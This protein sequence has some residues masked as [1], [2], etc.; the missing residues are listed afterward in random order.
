MPITIVPVQA[1]EGLAEFVNL[2]WTVYADDPSW[3]PPLRQQ[4]WHELSDASAFAS[5]GRRQLYLCEVDGRPVGRIGASVN[6]RLV[7]ANGVV[8]GQLGYF[9]CVNDQT[10]AAALVEAGVAWL[11][12]QGAGEIIGPMNGGAH[13]T[14]RFMTRGFDRDPFMFEVR[15]PS[16]Y[17]TLFEGCGFVAT[18][19]W[20]GFELDR[21]RA[22]TLVAQFDRV[23]TRRPPPGR[24]VDMAAEPL[25]AIV[26]RLHRLLDGCWHGHV[27][28][29]SIDLAEF[30]E[31]FGGALPIMGHRNV[32]VLERDGRD[33]GFALIYPDY[34]EDVRALAGDAAGWGSWLGTARPERFVLH[35]A[36]L[37]PDARVGSAAMAQVNWGLRT[38][39]EGGF[40]RVVIAL[41]V[42]GFI[43]RI[44]DQTREYA[45]YAY[46]K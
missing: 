7:D 27:G 3:I 40:E 29:A 2:P 20:F 38:A 42:E 12:A 34:A 5:Y 26:G 30:A 4:V 19:R 22:E 43:S 11:R 6:P 25:E 8:V 39:V 18:H 37:V 33:L 9:E 24:I 31:V 23:M 41:A 1:Q 28:Y 15:N 36:A 21:R 46:S 14:H 44:G 35:T 13:R 16:Y 32:S 17:P 45:L 10:I